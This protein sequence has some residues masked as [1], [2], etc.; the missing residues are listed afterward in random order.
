MNELL[1]FGYKQ[2]ELNCL[3]RMESREESR[4]KT[5]GCYCGRRVQC[6]KATDKVRI[7]FGQMGIVVYKKWWR[8]NG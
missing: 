3:W 6:T 4:E 7:M 5:K 2:A 8:D 1:N